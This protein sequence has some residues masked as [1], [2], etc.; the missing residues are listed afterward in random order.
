[1]AEIERTRE[2]ERPPLQDNPY[3]RRGKNNGKF[4]PL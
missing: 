4:R 3:E 1:M 2:R